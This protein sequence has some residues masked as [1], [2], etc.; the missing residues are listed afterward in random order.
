[1][2]RVSIPEVK[3]ETIAQLGAANSSNAVGWVFSGLTLDG[4]PLVRTRVHTGD[5]FSLDLKR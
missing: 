2:Q 5:I 3:V 1:M 4:T